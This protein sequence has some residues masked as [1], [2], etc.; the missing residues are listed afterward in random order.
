MEEYIIGGIFFTL[1]SI[2]MY[3][4]GTAIVDRNES[5]SYK[6]V[7]GYLVY[8]FFVAVF[9]IIVQVINLPWKIFEIYMIFL[10]VIFCV[11]STYRIRK[12]N[13]QVFPI[14]FKQFINEHWFLFFLLLFMIFLTFFH[15]R[16]YWFNNHLDD[17]FYI[18]K[19]MVYPHV[20]NPFRINPT[21]GLLN[22]NNINP[23]IVNTHELEASF[24]VNLLKMTPTLYARLFLAGFHY[25]LFINCIYAFSEKIM[26]LAKIKYN[27]NTLQYIPGIIILFAFNELFLRNK[28]ILFLQDSNQFGNAMYYGS[29]VV[30]TMGIMLLILPFLDMKKI[31]LKMVITVVCTSIVLVSKSTIALP[32]IIATSISFVLTSFVCS[33]KLGRRMFI[34][35][36]LLLMIAN[37]FFINN[38]KVSEISYY[39]FKNFKNNLSLIGFIPIIIIF[40][41]SFLYKSSTINKINIFFVIFFV[42]TII[43]FFNNCI[44]FTSFYSFV[45]GRTFTCFYYTLCI[46]ACIYVH[47]FLNNIQLNK[48]VISFLSIVSAIS[49]GF[50]SVYSIQIAGGSLFYDQ[51]LYGLDLKESLKIIKNNNKFVPTSSLKLGEIL[52]QLTKDEEYEIN[53]LSRELHNVNGAAYALA[54]SLTSLAPNVKSISSIF[55]YGVGTNKEFKDFSEKDQMIYEKFMFQFDSQVYRKFKNLLIKYPINCVILVVDDKTRYMEEMGFE[56]YDKVI[57]ENAGVLYYVYKK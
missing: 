36:L 20:N 52:N 17:S 22:G 29:S 40:I 5:Y 19:M 8:S 24:Y 13:K 21:T 54:T 31:N 25:S 56:L 35:I 51:Q 44:S 28:G 41:L 34:I 11:W 18:N 39:A 3:L 23:Y 43:P 14:N 26:I 4:V 12:Y 53:V 49:L 33:D 1:F 48:V 2:F 55:R 30:R 37:C 45:A 42:V 16:S 47:I 6:F 32:I 38:D 57:D 15:F 10:L 50:G 46:L 9:G 27:K 7:I